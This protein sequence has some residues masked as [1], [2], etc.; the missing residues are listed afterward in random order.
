[1]RSVRSS[2]RSRGISMSREGGIR[3]DKIYDNKHFIPPPHPHLSHPPLP[4]SSLLP[5]SRS[6]KLLSL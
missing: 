5:T 1:V 6:L 2:S 3:I 4:S